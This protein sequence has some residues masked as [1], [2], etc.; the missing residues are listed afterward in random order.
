MSIR[1]HLHITTITVPINTPTEEEEEDS[2]AHLQVPGH[3]PIPTE[4]RANLPTTQEATGRPE[5]ISHRTTRR[6][7]KHIHRTEATTATRLAVAEA[8]MEAVV[9]VAVP[10]A[11]EAVSP[12]EAVLHIAEEV[13]SPEE[14]AAD[15]KQIT[16]YSVSTTQ[17]SLPL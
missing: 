8:V 5:A 9:E 4:A 2:P 7:A 6:K 11:E 1:H 17:F 16:Y 3:S 10:L 12:E 14:E 13:V 15:A